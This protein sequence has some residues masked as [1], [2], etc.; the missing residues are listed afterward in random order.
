MV[1][2][3]LSSSLRFHFSSLVSFVYFSFQLH[4][5]VKV[6]LCRQGVVPS[7]KCLFCRIL[8]VSVLFGFAAHFILMC[9]R[10]ESPNNRPVAST[11]ARKFYFELSLIFLIWGPNAM[12]LSSIFAD[13]F[14]IFF[15][16]KNEIENFDK[17]NWNFSMT[18]TVFLSRI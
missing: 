14:R 10:I 12:I 7:T 18:K 8:C 6:L 3:P 9:I 5:F 15:S 13:L 16:R 4:E 17:F 1:F 11:V 2:S